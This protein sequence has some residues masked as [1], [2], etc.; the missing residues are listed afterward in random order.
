MRD[1]GISNNTIY[2]KYQK[3]I[4][5][6]KSGYRRKVQLLDDKIDDFIDDV[7]KRIQKEEE[8]PTY[9]GK[10]SQLLANMNKEH[11]EFLMAIKRIA[12]TIDSGTKTIPKTQG[13]AQPNKMGYEE[14][15]QQEP[16]NGMEK[17]NVNEEKLYQ[18]DKDGFPIGADD[19]MK[20]SYGK[21]PQSK[22]F[23]NMRY[24]YEIPKKIHGW[25][26]STTFGRW[27]ALVTFKDGTKTWTYPKNK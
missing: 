22:E 23:Q 2:E 17:E 13:H 24:G 11:S 15:Q 27:T 20:K 21:I 7:E 25:A 16:E 8:N 1:V 10:L 18:R 26:W 3:S 4:N 5:E 14:P 12:S 6:A 19:I 9:Q